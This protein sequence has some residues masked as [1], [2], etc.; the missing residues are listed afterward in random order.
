MSDISARI[1]SCNV[2]EK[3]DTQHPVGS[4]SDDLAGIQLL[5]Q[6]TNILVD[7]QSF[8]IRHRQSF[9]LLRARTVFSPTRISNQQRI[10]MGLLSLDSSGFSGGQG[11]GKAW[12]MDNSVVL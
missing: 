6:V 9:Y 3:D 8:S 2:Q 12:L 1:V 7:Y 4:S 10:L 5:L 11:H